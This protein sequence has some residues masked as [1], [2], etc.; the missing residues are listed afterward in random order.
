MAHFGQA[1]DEMLANA[2]HWAQRIT[3]VRGELIFNIGH[4]ASVAGQ[5]ILDSVLAAQ[6][7]RK[8]GTVDRGVSARR[9]ANK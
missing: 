1:V 5:Y 3:E 8:R 2:P 9:E 4:S 7:K 6:T